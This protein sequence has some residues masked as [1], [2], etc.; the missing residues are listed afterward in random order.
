MTEESGQDVWLMVGIDGYPKGTMLIR[1]CDNEASNKFKKLTDRTLPLGIH[2]SIFVPHGPNKVGCERPEL[3]SSL[4]ETPSGDETEEA[5][6]QLADASAGDVSIS[7]NGFSICTGTPCKVGE[8]VGHLVAGQDVLKAIEQATSLGLSS[9]VL[10]CGVGEPEELPFRR[11][12][13]WSMPLDVL[14][15]TS[16]VL[17]G[18]MALTF[19]LVVQ[20]MVDNAARF[21]LLV[22]YTLILVILLIAG[23]IV[24]ST[25][26][27]DPI[28]LLSPAVAADQE[29]DL[30][31]C[32]KCDRDVVA[33]SRHCLLCNKCC[34]HFD[35]HCRWLN[36]CIGA[37]NYYPFLVVLG[38]LVSL[39]LMQ[40]GLIISAWVSHTS[41]DSLQD[42][43]NEATLS[44]SCG[45]FHAVATLNI[46]VSLAAFLLSAQLIHL[47][48]M[49]HGQGMTT[50]DYFNAAAK[51]EAEESSKV[52]AEVAE[53]TDV[54][55]ESNNGPTSPAG[56]LPPL[57]K[58][59]GEPSASYALP[60]SVPS[61]GTVDGETAFD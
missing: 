61:M 42:W 56:E 23:G 29:V 21:A 3:H 39:S 49:L 8:L 60:G 59:P 40:I 12:N 24:T 11:K 22:L 50:F 46:V 44:L 41:C 25:D 9:V 53:D 37:A 55:A 43:L 26:P 5:D 57:K 51:Q 35:H 15:C 20:H 28:T 31:Y 34:H 45:S 33:T 52:E 16:W 54:A 38:G 4:L 36:N 19:Y 30:A 13:G 18:F 6:E 10:D 47:H 2:G 48:W 17:I 58:V 32:T 14:Q 1:L 7:P 27:I